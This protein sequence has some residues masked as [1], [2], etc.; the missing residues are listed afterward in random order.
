[1]EG[2]VAELGLCV[3][4]AVVVGVLVV[5]R[6]DAAVDEPVGTLGVVVT[7]LLGVCVG[8]TV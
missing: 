7:V 2:V 1:L 8:L 5:E 4:V 6:V 3:P